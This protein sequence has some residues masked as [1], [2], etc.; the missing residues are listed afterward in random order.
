MNENCRTESG[1]KRICSF[2]RF[3]KCIRIGVNVNFVL[4]R[5]QPQ[6]FRVEAGLYDQVVSNFNFAFIH[7]SIAQKLIADSLSTEPTLWDDFNLTVVEWPITRYYLEKTN[8][9]EML[10]P[11]EINPFIDN[12]LPFWFF[13]YCT[14]YTLQNDGHNQNRLHM[15]DE[16]GLPVIPDASRRFLECAPFAGLQNVDVVSAKIHDVHVAWMN[17]VYNFHRN[18]METHE[19][20]IICHILT[21]RLAIE[22]FPRKR[23]PR[24]QLNR[25][26][27]AVKQTF[28]GMYAN[29]EVRMGNLVFL[30]NDVVNVVK[31]MREWETIFR[32]NMMT[33]DEAESSVDYFKQVVNF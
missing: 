17:G 23:E 28:N 9:L 24:E 25:L 14:F 4:A 12:L 10:E 2:C 33:S 27:Y 8:V 20:A 11:H 15:I 13:V 21:L 1:S 22:M 32:L 3:R 18:H 7:R 26:F 16:K 5:H 29:A 6:S 31:E 30:I 19:F